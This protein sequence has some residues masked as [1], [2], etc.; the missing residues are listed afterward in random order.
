M[1]SSNSGDKR[2]LYILVEISLNKKVAYLLKLE[3]IW[4]QNQVLSPPFPLFET[5]NI[6]RICYKNAKKRGGK[7]GSVNWNSE[8]AELF[9]SL[10]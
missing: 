8:Y 7:D 2:A 6:V 4:N 1:K 10:H 9:E 5:D 3:V